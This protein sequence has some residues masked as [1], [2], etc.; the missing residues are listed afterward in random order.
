MSGNFHSSAV[1]S[2]LFVDFINASKLDQFLIW[3]NWYTFGIL[4]SKMIVAECLPSLPSF[5]LMECFHCKYMFWILNRKENKEVCVICFEVRILRTKHFTETLNSN[6]F[7]YEK[8]LNLS[9]G[10]MYKYL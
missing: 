2:V 3:K 6:F 5:F 4:H 10:K 8:F 9:H 1:H 7:Q